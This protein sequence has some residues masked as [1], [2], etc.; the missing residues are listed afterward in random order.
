MALASAVLAVYTQV[1]LTVTSTQ[2][3]PLSSLVILVFGYGLAWG[4]PIVS[5]VE[6]FNFE[7]RTIENLN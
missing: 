4:L 3:L 1:D 7:V 6:I 2:W 5:M